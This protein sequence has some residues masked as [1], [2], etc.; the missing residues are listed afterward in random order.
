VVIFI[1]FKN[2]FYFEKTVENF[3]QMNGILDLDRDCF[4]SIVRF[5]SA[6]SCR[7]Y[8]G[9][10]EETFQRK[11]HYFFNVYRLKSDNIPVR[12]LVQYLFFGIKYSGRSI[13]SQNGHQIIVLS[14]SIFERI[15]ELKL[16]FLGNFLQVKQIKANSVK[17]YEDGSGLLCCK[18]I[19]MFFE[20]ADASN[21][22]INSNLYHE[23]HE[24]IMTVILDMRKGYGRMYFKINDILL[25][26][27]IYNI[28]HNKKQIHI[29]VG[30]DE[31]ATIKSIKDLTVLPIEVSE[32]CIYY[33]S[34]NGEIV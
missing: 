24:N 8:I 27:S 14:E 23:S 33:D 11:E 12:R 30:Y 17:R 6:K 26:C 29:T 4:L 13:V 34:H 9:I 21:V 32:N 20:N 3:D 16:K 10:S 28:S 1:L 25:P 2:I 5:L 19:L 22:C 18:R 15:F 31:M 7:K